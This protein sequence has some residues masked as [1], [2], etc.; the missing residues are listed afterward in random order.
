[1]TSKPDLAVQLHFALFKDRAGYVLKPPEMRPASDEQDESTATCFWPPP[2]ESLHRATLH[3][4]SLHNL[5]KV[6]RLELILGC[7]LV[8]R[9]PFRQHGRP[10]VS[11]PV[12]VCVCRHVKC[13]M[14]TRGISVSQRGEQRPC[15]SGAR[16]AAHDYHPELSGKPVPPDNLDVSSPSIT[17]SLHPI[18]GALCRVSQLWK[19]RFL[20]TECNTSTRTRS[21]LVWSPSNPSKPRAPATLHRLLRSREGAAAATKHFK[22]VRH[23]HGETQWSERNIRRDR[24]FCR[25]SAGHHYPTNSS[26]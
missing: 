3:V 23:S 15:Y 20:A 10:S 11:K 6:G 25:C 4:L 18:G 17:L 1:M 12:C 7:S 8:L 21:T 13:V 16:Q 22:R 24:A 2:R 19:A 9:H 26:D 5:P 14:L